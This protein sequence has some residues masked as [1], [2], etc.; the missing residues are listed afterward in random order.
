[1]KI[2]ILVISTLILIFSL[3]PASAW[4]TEARA[5]LS[6]LGEAALD[7]HWSFAVLDNNGA[8]F[9][10][11]C[12]RVIGSYYLKSS[13]STATIESYGFD[14]IATHSRSNTF[15]NV[16]E[17]SY[18][19][20]TYGTG[21][22]TWACDYAGEQTS[23]A[24]SSIVEVLF[25]GAEAD[26]SDEEYDPSPLI[27]DLDHRGFRFTDAK[28]GV[29]FD[30]DADGVME[31]IAWTRAGSGDAFLALDRN[32]N[33]FVDD[34]IELF[35]NYTSQ[36]VSSEPNGFEALAIF[37]WPENGGNGDGKISQ[38]DAV[39]SSLILWTDT[40]HDGFSQYDEMNSLEWHEVSSISLQYHETWRTDKHGN[41]LRFNGH[42][43]FEGAGSGNLTDVF[44]L[45]ED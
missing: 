15:P 22:T 14:S 16:D 12:S 2:Q 40:N 30:I 39:Y 26:E 45:T 34:G 17:G 44:F 5:E 18:Y 28:D 7:A 21:T 11:N 41:L 35:G 23:S 32:L 37:D 20:W 42:F 25:G 43:R 10:G 8:P 1:M 24:T 33:G 4:N 36:P 31:S 19:T 3:T 29:E 27:L 9:V 6:L 13:P 38:S